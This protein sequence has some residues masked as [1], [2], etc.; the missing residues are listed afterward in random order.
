VTVELVAGGLDA[1]APNAIEPKVAV[2]A[3]R[4]SAVSAITSPSSVGVAIVRARV[5]VEKSSSLTFIAI[6]RPAR[7]RALTPPARSAA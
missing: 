7:P 4:A 2:A 1:R 6:V 5:T 3:S